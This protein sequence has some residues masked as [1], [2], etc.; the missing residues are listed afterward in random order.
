MN[1]FLNHFLITLRLNFRNKQ[2]LAFG[3]IV[4]VFFLFA[5]GSVFRSGGTPL[6]KELGQ[7]ITISTLGGACFGMPVA[8]VTER[9]RG[10]WRRYRLAP[11]NSLW[12]VAS[13]MAV[14]YIIIMTSALLQVA[15]AMAIYKMPAPLYP[16][17]LLIAFSFV[18]FAF[19][20]MGL[21]IAMIANSSGAVQALGQSIFLPMIMIGG[22]GFPLRTLPVWAQHVAAF[23]PGRYAVEALGKCVMNS[24]QPYGLEGAWFQMAALA[25]IGIA[26]CLIASKL[27]RWESEQRN[28][29]GTKWWVMLGLCTWAAVGLAAECLD[30]AVAK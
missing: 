16:F 9:E 3:Y 8:L 15:L 14:R 7:L 11:I 23:L 22:V 29:P 4:P 18:S 19:L 12:F 13:T 26:F 6:V 17:Q 5:Y 10:V 30:L 20:S 28:S 27:F 25:V 2:A 1:G 24:K 21:V